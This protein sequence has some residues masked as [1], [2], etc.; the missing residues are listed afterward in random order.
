MVP[1]SQN[2]TL[3]KLGINTYKEA[4]LYMRSDCHVCRSEGFEVHARVKVSLNG[5]SILATLNTTQDGL[6]KPGEVSLS[7]YA[8]ELLDA[9]ENE[10]VFLS[11]PK[12]LQSLSLVRAKVYGNELATHE[13]QHIIEDIAK[14]RYSD[15][16]I[17]TFISACAGGRLS[18]REIIDLTKAMVNMG[19]QITWPNTM[20]VDKHCVG[21]L[22]GNRT[23]LII[24]PIV[25]AFGLI[26]PKT[27]SRAITSPAGTAD[28]METLA[29][30]DLSINDIQRVIEQEG[31]CV[32]WGGAVQLSPADDILIRVER[33][34]ELDS[35]GQ[36]IASV[37]SK[38][39]AAGSTHIA[40]DIPFGPTAKIRSLN[41]AEKIK[42]LFECVAATLGTRVA[43]SITDGSQPVGRGIGPALE[44]KDV[45]A[46]LQNTPD[47]PNDLRERALTLA[48]TIIEFSPDVKE[49]E[50]KAIATK[51]LDEGK[52]WQK[53]Q[54]ICKAQGELREPPSA[55]FTH[56]ITA[57][58]KGRIVNI[59]NRQ[60]SRVA[61]L[62]GA[63]FDSAAGV[64]LHTPLQTTVEKDQPLFTIHADSKGELNYAL[65]LVLEDPNII[66]LEAYT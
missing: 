26:I 18:H 51:L 8:W 63:P 16:H 65:S 20:V 56:P 19:Q 12:P 33:A 15:I 3:K 38:K 6:L 61:K 44:A 57:K 21:G 55:K 43:I 59:N 47:A 13:I 49:G 2:L 24:V 42:S 35:E 39:I 48:G 5:K 40:I 36:L 4:I 27:S 50:G 66:Q 30:V 53:F 58:G 62:A 1:T 64:V 11:H 29:P 60:L 34:I 22:P 37:L 17:A 32:V 25:A 41:Q 7:N 28:T 46:V 31:G 45:L 52:A 23:T 54:A 14:G 10:E 9:K